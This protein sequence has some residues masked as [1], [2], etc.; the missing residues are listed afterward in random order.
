MYWTNQVHYSLMQCVHYLL[1]TVT[2]WSICQRYCV[3]T[4]SSWEQTLLG[5]RVP[6]QGF[7]L[8]SS[9]NRLGKIDSL[10]LITCL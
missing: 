8:K 10:A 7:V 3:E 5:S 6:E 9:L 2:L 1:I 4:S